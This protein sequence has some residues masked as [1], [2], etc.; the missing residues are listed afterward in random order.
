M[1]GQE[2]IARDLG[3]YLAIAQDEVRQHGEYRFTRG[4]LETPDGEAAQAD[5]GIMR[6]AR[7]APTA[8]TGRLVCS[9][10]AQGQDKGEHAF[11]KGFAIAQELTIGGFV[12]KIDGDGPIGAGL[13]SGVSHGSPSGQMV[14]ATDDPRWG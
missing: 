2:G 3:A 5:T 11:D 8:T 13:V 10:K 4:T 14:G 9:L 1:G 7:Q 6:V 12:V